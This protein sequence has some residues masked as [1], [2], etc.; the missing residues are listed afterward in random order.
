M[1]S[2]DGSADDDYNENQFSF[3]GD[4]GATTKPAKKVEAKVEEPKKAV[5]T[6]KKEIEK[7]V[8]KVANNAKSAVKDCTMV[9]GALLRKLRADKEIMLWV[10]CQDVTVK[11]N[12]DYLL[13]VAPGENEY[14]LLSRQENV[15]KLSVYLSNEGFEGVKIVKDENGEMEEQKGDE[16]TEQVKQ[17]FEGENLNIK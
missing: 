17:Y 6:P 3:M 4:F 5:E 16:S 11:A 15:N 13:V 14:D 1:A 2:Y 8:E 12:G 9:W 10:A 7:P